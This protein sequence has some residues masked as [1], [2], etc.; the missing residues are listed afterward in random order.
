MRTL[1]AAI[2]VAWTLVAVAAVP[3]IAQGLVGKAAPEI[4]ATY[5]LNS[6][7][8]TLQ[9][10]RGKIV[11]VEFWATWCGPCR[12]SIPHLIELYKKYNPQGVVFIGLTDEPREKVEPFA[13][14]LEMIY[15]V[16]G[17]STSSDAYGVRGIPRAFLVD[18]AGN[19]VWE[20]HP[21]D[22]AFATALEE[23]MKK[24]P[25]TLMKPEEQAA[26]VAALDKVEAAIKKED[27]KTAAAL[28]AAI[29]KPDAD[30]GVK[31]RVAEVRKALVA[32]AEKRLEEA[33]KSLAAKDYFEASQA[34]A[35]VSALAPGSDAAKKAKAWLK[36]LQ[37][38]EASRSAI[39]QGRR[40]RDAAAV[41]AALDAGAPR[42][43]P[44]AVLKALDGVAA[45]FPATR[46]GQAAADKAKAMRADSALMGK[47]QADAADKECKGWISMARSFIKAGMPDKAKP[48]LDQVLQKYP[49]TTYAEEA[50]ELLG[51]M[52]K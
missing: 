49:G 2:L 13:K 38:D 42:M 25:P 34:L 37:A 9:G 43:S 31:T 39:E 7:A 19:V 1:T 14:E 12:R 4:T 16:G 40:E 18:T 33:E 30:P 23:Q 28:L 20:G 35:E 41:L 24:T 52:G 22:T 44:V 48:Y 46:A 3:A 29:A 27:Y 51:E 10:L 32:A 17:G 5:W 6:P 36:E 21:M 47:V 15:A 45:K 8:L 50:K 11:V 26:A